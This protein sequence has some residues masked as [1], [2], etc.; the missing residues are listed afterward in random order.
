MPTGTVANLTPK[1]GFGFLKSSDGGADVFFHCSKFRGNFDGIKLGEVLE[2]EF[3]EESDDKPRAKKTWRKGES[4][5][6]PAPSR[7]G[8]SQDRSGRP[9]NV[10]L[11][12]VIRL[13][14]GR[15]EG[16]ISPTVGGRE[17]LFHAV[18]VKGTPYYK[19]ELGQ[20]VEFELAYSEDETMPPLAEKVVP[21]ERY[22]N[23]KVP[24]LNKHPRAR[25]K[26]PTWRGQTS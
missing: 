26:K 12:H 15:R 13:F 1:K 4:E 22:F 14:R 17:V 3:D 11:G 8:K 7:R 19:L 25:G 16:S 24:R 10:L 18:A 6:P 9:T 23:P 5:P 20:Y 21:I 2:F